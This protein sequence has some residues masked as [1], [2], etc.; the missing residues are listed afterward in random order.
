MTQRIDWFLVAIAGVLAL[1]VG[2]HLWD[3]IFF[4][5]PFASEDGVMEYA[6]IVFLA[7]SGVVLLGNAA[8]L[9]RR[10]TT[11]GAALTVLYALVFFFGAGEEMSWGQRIFGW[12][13]G[14][15]FKENNFQGETNIHNLVVGSSQLAETLFGNVLT[16]AILLYLVVLPP[17]YP[18]LGWL[19]RLVDR[20]AVPVPWLRH[21]IIAV[22]A[23]LVIAAMDQERKW[24]VYELIFSLLTV[25]IFLNPQNRDET[26]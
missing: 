2:I 7:L 9:W 15:Y 4:V 17:L 26:R 23:S 3:P 13:S 21:G 5:S 18:R 24:E 11:L 25:S 1:S 14:D 8:A 6:T 10:G 16:A 12:E 22:A 19:R 20:L